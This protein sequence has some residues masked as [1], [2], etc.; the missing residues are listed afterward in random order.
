MAASALA[1]TMGTSS[2][3]EGP[4]GGGKPDRVQQGG[5]PGG[6]QEARG[7]K[8]DRKPQAI[9]QRDGPDREV[10]GGGKPDMRGN[11]RGRGSDDRGAQARG[12]KP[13][14]IKPNGREQM[15][16]PGQPRERGAARLTQ[17]RP[18]PVQDPGSLARL[19]WEPDQAIGR[20]CPPG[21][22]KKNNG[23][24]PPGQARQLAQQR[25]QQNWYRNWWAY[26]AAASYFYDDGYLLGVNGDSVDSFIPLLGGALWKGQTWPA[27]Y[28]ALPV[29]DYHVDYLGLQDG[30]DYRLADGAIYGVDP[31]TQ[32]IQN[33]AALVAGDAWAIGQ[34]MPAGY[35]IYNVPYEYR[36]DYQDTPESLY[37]YADGYVYQVDPTTQLIQAAIQLIT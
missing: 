26:P 17:R 14:T 5:G 13:E 25:Q 32:L 28:E 29:P 8:P 33:V 4:R 9:A 3:A 34:P 24:L 2:L 19:S 6:G 1:L 16:A 36:D 15:A 10:R 22:A 35:D 27:S 18:M 31:A 12:G 30:Y 7:R 21:L 23:C 11:G 20:G 37:R